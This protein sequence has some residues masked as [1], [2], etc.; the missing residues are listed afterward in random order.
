MPIYDVIIIGTGPAGMSAGI[1]SGVYK[2]K[3]MI[4]GKKIGGYAADAYKIMNYP[5]FSSIG[6]IELMNK[7]KKHLDEFNIPV[8][9]EVITKIDKIKNGFQINTD[10]TQYSAKTVIIATGSDRRK[11]HIPGEKEL[12][13]R[14][15]S[16]CATCDAIFFRN[17]TVI[18]VGGSDSALSSASYLANIAEKVFL[19]FRKDNPTA[20]PMWIQKVKENPKIIIVAK[21][22]I[23][24]IIGSNLVTSIQ[25]DR[26]YQK[27]N[28]L[29]VDG[30]FIEIGTIP[31]NNLIKNLKVK[32]DEKGFIVVDKTQSTNVKGIYAAGD[33]T[34]GS[35]GFEQI[36]TACAEGAISANSVF[37]YLQNNN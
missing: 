8:K 29:K 11:L 1:Y 37:K 6:G 10:K 36:I 12:I 17:K 31:L 27:E 25:L 15:V 19:I 3:S 4:L 28:E 35:N 5:G 26:P 18:V 20:L 13:G 7:F 30:V 22:N 32:I 24:K 9:T 2:L 34:V 21:T 14:G 33:V 16:Y 23:T